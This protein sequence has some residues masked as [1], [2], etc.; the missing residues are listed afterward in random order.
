MST[1]SL[2]SS[3]PNK[4]AAADCLQRPLLRRSRFRQRLSASV[5]MTSS[6]KGFFR[7]SVDCAMFIVCIPRPS[8]ER[9]PVITTV[10]HADIRGL[11]TT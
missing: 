2:P 6:V 10:D 8:E 9:E 4:R 7:E 3:A 5:D 11:G 1:V